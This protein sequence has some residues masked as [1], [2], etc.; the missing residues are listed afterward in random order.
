MLED[1]LAKI[2]RFSSN[3][4]YIQIA[5]ETLLWK[6]LERS[7]KKSKRSAE[8]LDIESS[9]SQIVENRKRK[10]KEDKSEQIKRKSEIIKQIVAEKDFFPRM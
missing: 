2:P 6:G 5:I 1:L 3:A 4:L 10:R 8:M 9:Y 7:K